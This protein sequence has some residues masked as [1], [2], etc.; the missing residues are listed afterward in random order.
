MKMVGQNAEKSHIHTLKDIIE[1]ASHKDS[2]SDRYVEKNDTGYALMKVRYG[3][4]GINFVMNFH[5]YTNGIEDNFN[6]TEVNK[7]EST[8]IFPENK[9]A[10]LYESYNKVKY[11]IDIS[12]EGF[13]YA[14]IFGI[15]T[16]YKND[17]TTIGEISGLVGTASNN[18]PTW[19]DV[20]ITHPEVLKSLRIHNPHRLK[21]E[22]DGTFYL[23]GM[24]ILTSYN[25]EF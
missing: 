5:G 9:Y 25:M 12:R 10:V 2:L 3:R 4:G 19:R 11:L 13:K 23:N 20:I 15:A 18:D 8:R 22:K 17:N 21:E 14:G 7:G 1:E 6:F 24:P 16:G